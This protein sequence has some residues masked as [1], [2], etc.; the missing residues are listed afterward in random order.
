MNRNVAPNAVVQENKN[1]APEDGKCI[2]LF[3]RIAAK[4]LLYPLNQAE[5]N[6]STA[7]NAIKLEK[8]NQAIKMTHLYESFFLLDK[9]VV[10][11]K[12]DN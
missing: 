1:Y 9:N 10:W 7:K 5:T 6:R 4:K 8:I 2:P 3:A 12:G 11:S